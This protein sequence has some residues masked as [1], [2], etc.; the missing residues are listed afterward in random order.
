MDNCLHML[1]ACAFLLSSAGRSER[2]MHFALQFYNM[3]K[4]KRVIGPAPQAA[5]RTAGGEDRIMVVF[6][7]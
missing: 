4:Q 5:E 7:M 1:L 6:G 2:G 3:P